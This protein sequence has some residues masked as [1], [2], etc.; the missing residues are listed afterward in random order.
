MISHDMPGKKF[1][2]F[3]SPCWPTVL[4]KEI[5]I[6]D[7]SGSSNCPPPPPHS[8]T[9]NDALRVL[10]KKTVDLIIKQKNERI[11]YKALPS[12]VYELFMN[13][14]EHYIASF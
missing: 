12:K 10:I 9:S 14:H 3:R 1:V 8:K 5:L 2:T 6:R 7:C 13:V 11:P 4:G